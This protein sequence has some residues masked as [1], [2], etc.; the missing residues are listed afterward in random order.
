MRAV[1]GRDDR[2]SERRREVNVTTTNKRLAGFQ[3]RYGKRKGT[4][5]YT[6][7]QRYASNVRWGKKREARAALKEVQELRAAA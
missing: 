6:A 1:S 5:L 3:A 4:K 2:R 7:I